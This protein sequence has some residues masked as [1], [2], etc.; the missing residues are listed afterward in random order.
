MRFLSLLLLSACSA[1][2]VDEYEVCALEVALASPAG[3]PGD[4]ITL[5]G[6]PFTSVRDTR[7]EV[8]GV[9]ATVELVKRVDI[10][11][12]AERTCASNGDC[13]D[14]GGICG[15]DGLCAPTFHCGECDTCRDQA[16][17]APCGLCQ[18]LTLEPGRRIECFGDALE[19]TVGHCDQCQETMIF[20]VPAVPPGLTAVF[21]TNRNGQS[22]AI[23]FE[24]L[25]GP[26]GTGD[27]GAGT[28]DTGTTDTGTIDT[29]A[30]TG[31]TGAPPATGDTSSDTAGGSG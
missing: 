21:V 6:T 11:E 14:C 23:P 12:C 15:G 16:G 28:G 30:P 8:G 7:V 26:A 20:V 1:T 10:G 18:G 25:P 31:D 13:S 3:A 22:E 4:A 17:C 24:V 5:T 29:G 2:A 9:P 27:T 19:G